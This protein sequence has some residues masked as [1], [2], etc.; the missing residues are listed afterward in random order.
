MHAVICM[1]IRIRLPDI[2]TVDF[3]ESM[4]NEQ[5]SFAHLPLILFDD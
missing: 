1:S 4:L 2:I 5:L 3:S